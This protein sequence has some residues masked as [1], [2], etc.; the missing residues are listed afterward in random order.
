MYRSLENHSL[1]QKLSWLVSDKSH[2]SDC[3]QPY[4][5]LCQPEYAEATLIC[6][7]AVERN[8]PSLMSEINPCL[9][10][11]KTNAKEFHKAHRRCSSFPDNHFK[12]VYEERIWKCNRRLQDTT[13]FNTRPKQMNI[14]GKLKPWHSMPSL[15]V[16][17]LRV[18][19]QIS[20]YCSKTTPSTPVHTKKISKL[21]PSALKVDYNSLQTKSRKVS[22][23]KNCT[24]NPHEV[25]HV[26]INNCNIVEHTPPLSSS[27]SS[28]TVPNDELNYSTRSMPE[29]KSK[30]NLAH[31]PLS[32]VDSFLPMPGEKDYKKLPKKT[33]IEDGGMS[34]LP[35]ATGYFPKPTKGQS[36]LSFLTSS[37]FARANAELDRENAHFNISEAIISAM[38][39]IRCK[40]ESKL[41]DEQLDDSDPEIMDLKQRIRLRRRQKEVEKHRKVWAATMLSE[42]KTESKFFFFFIKLLNKIWK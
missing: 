28:G 36:L 15:Q 41:I 14:Q 8:Q 5:F 2:V 35:M 20:A 11:F 13:K 18:R 33:F 16:D 6:L 12:K 37:Q 29:T 27:Q 22:L 25:K 34:V 1:S 38:E 24:W 42:A 7:R 17:S 26:L 9:F 32:V 10:L 21:S 19:E 3:Y 31:S 4:A 39:Q 40:R 30:S 23:K